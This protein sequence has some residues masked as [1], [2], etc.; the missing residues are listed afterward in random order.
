MSS[1][2]I[3]ISFRDGVRKI[4]IDRPEKHNALSQIMY[5]TLTDTLNQDAKD[6]KIIV[7]IITGAGQ[8]YSSGNDIKDQM[9]SDLPFEEKLNFAKDLI[10]AFI[11][12]PKILIAVV[13]GPAI[14]IAATTAALCDIVY[15]SEKAIFDTPFINLGLCAEGASSYTF[16]GILGRSKASEALLLNKKITAQD[17]YKFGLVSEVIAH[18]KIEGFIE[19][20]HQY[21]SL[22]LNTVKLNKKLIMHNLKNILTDANIREFEGLNECV[23]SE[24]FGQAVARF[25]SKK[26]SKL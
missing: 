18:D 4:L 21:G 16:P 7:T 20:L 11:D 17:A 6:D 1:K 5:K 9:N 14:G 15:A 26:K 12:Y 2:N 19:S 23:Y 25:M 22:P 8:Y 3:K 13:N 24:E 10:Q